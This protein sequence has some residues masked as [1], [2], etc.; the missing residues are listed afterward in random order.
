[1]NPR[2]SYAIVPGGYRFGVDGSIFK[3]DGTTQSRDAALAALDDHGS[4]VI[5]ALDQKAGRRL[6]PEELILGVKHPELRP[7]ESRPV[8]LPQTPAPTAN[9]GTV[10]REE[11]RKLSG[12]ETP[13]QAWERLEREHE[14]KLA[15]ADAKTAFD[16]DPERQRAIAHA[17]AELHA[18]KHDPSVSTEEIE[19]YQA[20]LQLAKAGNLEDY[21]AAD[22]QYRRTQAAKLA[23]AVKPIDDRISLLKARKA[24]IEAG[25]FRAPPPPVVV[26]AAPIVDTPVEQISQAD[27]AAQ[28][29]ATRA[30]DARVKAHRESKL[31]R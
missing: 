8:V 14:E 25:T 19:G 31:P 23:E 3:H 24:E 26:E 20:R 10:G 4:R 18:V 13:K 16:S 22:E 1:M 30:F 27:L 15:A 28:R 11:W 21:A 6:T 9:P 17:T 2:I 7:V 29:E 12:R 5:S